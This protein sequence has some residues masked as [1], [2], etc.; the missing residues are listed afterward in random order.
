M[1]CLSRSPRPAREGRETTPG[2]FASRM[3]L[4][5][6]S[7]SLALEH[8]SYRHPVG[9]LV[10]SFLRCG[11]FLCLMMASHWPT[12][13]TCSALHRSESCPFGRETTPNS[14]PRYGRE[15]RR[16]IEAACLPRPSSIGHRGS[17]M[18]LIAEQS[19]RSGGCCSETRTISAGATRETHPNRQVSPAGSAR[20]GTAA[21]RSSCG[22]A[23]HGRGCLGP[24]RLL[25]C[26][27][28]SLRRRH[29]FQLG[30]QATT[31]ATSTS[32]RRLGHRRRPRHRLGGALGRP[33]PVTPQQSQ[34]ESS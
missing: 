34:P 11:F 8:F 30:C 2:P 17:S 13:S 3:S 1:L 33:L 26:W 32:C 4:L 23:V 25:G 12:T 31:N 9:A 29:G 14:R 10:P 28:A 19:P 5:A 22:H 15:Y 27:C 7:H 18:R 20:H 6:V 16:L 24:S 21:A